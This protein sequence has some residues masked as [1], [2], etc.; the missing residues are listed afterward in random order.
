MKD[1]II[2]GG[3][4]TGSTAAS[5]LTMNGYHVTL[6]EREKFPR[7]HVGESLIPFNYSIFEELGVLDKMKSNY[8]RKPGV[9]INNAM[10]DVGSTWLFEGVISG[11]KALSFHVW[12]A[13]FDAMLLNR[14]RE[15]GA[16]VQEET[17]VIQAILDESDDYVKV[18]TKD[19]EG[20]E[21]EHLARFLIDASGQ[22]TFLARQLKDK[23]SYEGLNRV[24]T[25]NHW[26]YPNLDQTLKD[27]FIEIVHLGGEKLGW[28]WNIPLSQD[29]LSVGVVLSADYY[30]EQKKKFAHEEDWKSKIYLQELFESGVMKHRLQ[31]ADMVHET[32]VFGDYSYYTSRKYGENFAII[33]DASSFLDPVF[34]SGIYMGMN[35]AK[36]VS[37]SL[38]LKFKQ[39]LSA[40]E[41]LKNVFVKIEG[42]Y[43][44]VEKLIRNFYNPDA[45]AL[46]NLNHLS[47]QS[48]EK[49][50]TAYTIYH[51]LL[52]GDFFNNH[53]KYAKAIDLLNNSKKLEQYKN[54]IKK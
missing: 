31:N 46:S 27:G 5:Y 42:A 51:Y 15:L 3:G 14:C 43:K 53:E 13:S 12:R 54:F 39:N 23:T 52:A 45:I 20:K 22:Y 4:P 50:E 48:Y 16:E 25:S 24:A 18:I 37:Q 7:D 1:V 29:L 47:N 17:I 9:K 10:G 8:N 33:G 40:E 38:D 34:S 49:F 44:L 19:R 6:F 30:K 28:I 36:L 32:N 26:K 11:D 41:T 2:I 21:T 35:S